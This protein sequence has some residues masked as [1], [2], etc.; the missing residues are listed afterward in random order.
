MM[1]AGPPFSFIFDMNCR[2]YVTLYAAP[3]F[4]SIFVRC[5]SVYCMCMASIITVFYPFRVKH[6]ANLL[7]QTL[8][9]DLRHKT[10]S[11]FTSLSLSH[12]G[13]P[14]PSSFI[15]DWHECCQCKSTTFISSLFTATPY[16]QIDSIVIHSC[17][18][19]KVHKHSKKMCTMNFELKNILLCTKKRLQITVLLRYN[20][21]IKIDNFQLFVIVLRY[22]LTAISTL[23]AFIVITLALQLQNDETKKK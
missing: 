21:A 12:F 10:R 6:T 15:C 11:K 18:Y 1:T 4:G 14:S 13:S 17:C 3:G 16:S 20:N 9:I 23:T 8:L 5:V 19:N 22:K 7:K 2:F